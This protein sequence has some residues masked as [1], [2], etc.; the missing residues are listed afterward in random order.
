MAYEEASITDVELSGPIKRIIIAPLGPNDVDKGWFTELTM[1]IAGNSDS[2][3][4]L[5]MP[6]LNQAEMVIFMQS[7]PEGGHPVRIWVKGEMDVDLIRDNVAL[8][9][10][11]V[12]EWKIL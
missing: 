2:K 9:Y 12:E 7:L 5:R 6:F 1:V 8:H 4:S 11:E 10:I 3:M